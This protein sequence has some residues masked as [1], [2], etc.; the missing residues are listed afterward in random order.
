MS[1]YG[2]EI[3]KKV[4]GFTFSL[5]IL[6]AIANPVVAFQRE[7]N[8]IKV[9]NALQQEKEHPRLI[10]LIN[11]SYIKC[12]LRCMFWGDPNIAPLWTIIGV[13]LG[14]GFGFLVTSLVLL[15]RLQLPHSL[16]CAMISLL[17]DAA[18]IFLLSVMIHYCNERCTEGQC[19]V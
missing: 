19:P 6:I 7:E 2:G 15:S 4:L 5:L 12:M 8:L 18:V 14:V 16:F 10:K 1:C 17:C 11:W 13:L 3:V 9:S